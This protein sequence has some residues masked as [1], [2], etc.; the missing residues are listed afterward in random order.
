MT[1][2]A[3]DNVEEDCHWTVDRRIPIVFVF[4]IFM[5]TVT[6][7]WWASSI[8]SSISSMDYRVMNLEHKNAS[9]LSVFERVARLEGQMKSAND[10]LADIR[11]ELRSQRN[12]GN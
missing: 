6:A 5:Q 3:E 4:A 10:I 11:D 8:S 1:H 9:Y 7:V 2:V 12:R